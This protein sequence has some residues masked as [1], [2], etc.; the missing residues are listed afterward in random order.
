MDN[1]IIER[2]NKR[3]FFDTISFWTPFYLNVLSKDQ[4]KQ[5]V[6]QFCWVKIVLFN[7]VVYVFHR[8][9]SKCLLGGADRGG[10][11]RNKAWLEAV[12]MVTKALNLMDL[13]KLD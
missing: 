13:M 12:A 10:G 9:R 5:L 3:S 8:F 11:A 6:V 2:G 1:L 7:F 4:Y